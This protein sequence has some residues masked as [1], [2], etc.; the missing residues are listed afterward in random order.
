MALRVQN[1]VEYA[2]GKYVEQSHPRMETGHCIPLK[3]HT[4]SCTACSD[5]CPSGATLGPRE[6][7]WDLCIDCN[8]CVSAC[9]SRAIRSSA[10]VLD[11][12]LRSIESGAAEI[13]VGCEQSEQGAY[14]QLY[15]MGGIPW[16]AFVCLA[17][18]KQVILDTSHCGDCVECEGKT[19][20]MNNLK[21]ARDFLGV[22]YFDT[23]FV[24]SGS[25]PV[26]GFSRREAFSFL[27]GMGKS[28][29]ENIL[30]RTGGSVID[31]AFYMKALK[32]RLED[33]KPDDP[34]SYT[35]TTV[36]IGENC[37]ACSQ[38]KNICPTKAIDIFHDEEAG[39]YSLV[40]TA[41]LCTKCGLCLEA[42][43]DEAFLGLHEYQTT[44]PT[45]PL[46]YDTHPT[47]CSQCGRNFKPN[48]ETLCQP[49]IRSNEREAREEQKRK[50]REQRLEEARLKREA[51][52]KAKAEAEAAAK[53]ES[54]EKPTPLETD[55]TSETSSEGIS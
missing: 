3:K 40:H 30:V 15:C 1:A 25:Q 43:R 32:T 50:E 31:G 33:P 53:T 20:F 14:L 2:V 55:K 17:L 45:L 27:R 6:H 18:D 48:G 37:W 12:I 52:A 49:C 23:H 26:D 38:C 39:E 19:Q 16:E 11:K 35:L 13:V 51:E 5:I 34:K 54:S 8:L 10:D 47:V 7:N 41:M 28:V 42:C 46:A 29:A 22:D 44:D 9:P 36:D 24:E 4:M 21:K